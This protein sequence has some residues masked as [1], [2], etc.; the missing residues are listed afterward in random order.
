MGF[1]MIDL[2]EQ[3]TS[4]MGFFV[5]AFTPTSFHQPVFQLQAAVGEAAKE[6]HKKI[7]NA[8]S[9]EMPAAVKN[10]IT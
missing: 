9:V 2:Q 3:M 6:F 5:V 4:K 10:G 8:G 1:L 7:L